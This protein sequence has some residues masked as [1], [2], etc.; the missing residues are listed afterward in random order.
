MASGQGADR[1]QVAAPCYNDIIN[2]I[3]ETSR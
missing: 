1:Y 3:R 2:I